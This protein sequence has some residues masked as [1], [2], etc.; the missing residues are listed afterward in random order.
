MVKAIDPAVTFTDLDQRTDS[1]YSLMV[2]S[3]YLKAVPAGRNYE[4]GLPNGE[5]F[6]IFGDMFSRTPR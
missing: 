3:G 4:I 2:L 1:I 6:S 5:M